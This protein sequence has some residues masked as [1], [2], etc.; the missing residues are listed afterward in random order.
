MTLTVQLVLRALLADPAREMYGFEVTRATGLPSGTVYPILGRL[1][2]AGWLTARDEKIIPQEEGRPQRRYYKLT[3]KGI[4]EAREAT[5]RAA[6][7]LAVLGV[8]LG[9]PEVAA[10]LRASGTEIPV[11]TGEP[12]DCKHEGL[13]LSKGVCPDCMTYVA[14]KP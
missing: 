14:S 10:P 3:G 12:E 13:K 11:M 5:A 4:E 8:A 2:D 1:K 9:T 7:Q 6:V